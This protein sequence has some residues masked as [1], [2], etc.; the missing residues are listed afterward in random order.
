MTTQ[1]IKLSSFFPF[2]EK[3]LKE[4]FIE[5]GEIKMIPKGK[6]VVQEGS[7]MNFLPIILDGL[8]KMYA[9][10]DDVEFLLY[11]IKPN[12]SCILTFNSLFDQQPVKFSAKTEKDTMV[13]C[14]PVEK[15]KEWFVK[16]PSFSRIILKDFQHNY[17][18]LLNTTKQI[19]CYKIEDRLKKYLSEKANLVGDLGLEIS[20]RQIAADLGTSREVI[21]RIMK[22]LQKSGDVVQHKRHIEL[23]KIS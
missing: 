9:I 7:Y 11:Y 20:H 8:I 4:N 21:S 5:H 2:L 6:Y 3:E 14:L 16:Y 18:D 10:E 13:L 23:R 17:E 22:K 12:G 1:N 19:V 15:V